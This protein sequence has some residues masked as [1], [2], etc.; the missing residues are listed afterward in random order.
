MVLR[1]EGKVMAN[2]NLVEDLL[3]PSAN[4]KNSASSVSEI[5][6]ELKNCVSV[7]LLAVET[8]GIDGPDAGADE[9]N[10]KDLKHLIL[11]MNG[12]VDRLK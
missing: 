1:N 5:A 12:L 7:L 11:K 3:L 10:I 9:S 6:H 8:I 4:G 2:E